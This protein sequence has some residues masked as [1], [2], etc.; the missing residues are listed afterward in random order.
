MKI[1]AFMLH[2]LLVASWCYRQGDLTFCF[3]FFCSKGGNRVLV[4]AFG[5]KIGL[6]K[7]C[8]FYCLYGIV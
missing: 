1:R 4:Y 5:C 7:I 3:N 8:T 2:V 6:L